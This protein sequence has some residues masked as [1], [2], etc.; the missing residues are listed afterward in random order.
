MLCMKLITV[1]KSSGHYRQRSPAIDG[2]TAI[3]GENG[4]GKRQYPPV[5]RGAPVW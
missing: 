2:I 3:V 4:T 5:S 1:S